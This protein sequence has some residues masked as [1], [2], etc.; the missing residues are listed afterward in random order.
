MTS[1]LFMQFLFR[2]DR[3]TLASVSP[4]GRLG[5]AP[6]ITAIGMAG[7]PAIQKP[8]LTVCFASQ[9]HAGNP[10]L[11]RLC[12]GWLRFALNSD[13]PMAFAATLWSEALTGCLAWRTLPGVVVLAAVLFVVSRLFWRA[14]LRQ[15]SGPRPAG[16]FC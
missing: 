1:R 5:T 12:P 2:S 14:G 13:G 16:E 11:V 8:A 10:Q 4:L 6:I 7:V 9:G 3:Q 15:Y